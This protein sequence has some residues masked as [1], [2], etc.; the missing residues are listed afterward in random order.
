M[1]GPGE[2]DALQTP[3][4][5]FD[6]TLPIRWTFDGG[7][8]LGYAT[9]VS[10]NGFC[11]RTRQIHEPGFTQR[12]VVTVDEGEIPL[13]GRVAWTRQLQVESHINAWHEMGIELIGE[14]PPRYLDLVRSLAQPGWD[15]R[16]HQRFAA[17]LALKVR[18]GGQLVEAQAVD[19]S[20]TGLYIESE[21]TPG[22][23]E[24]L[25]LLLRLPGNA[26]PLE[27]NARVVRSPSAGSCPPGGFAVQLLDFSEREER[28]FLNYLKIVHEINSLSG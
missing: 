28:M 21:V 22:A 23:G 19:V 2:H 12:F 14:P 3:F 20:R 10:F 11:I 9:N 6:C 26:Q 27:L 18:R 16:L 13:M 15:R 8:E 4:E 25:G 1:T 5:L 24:Q 7:G 17:T